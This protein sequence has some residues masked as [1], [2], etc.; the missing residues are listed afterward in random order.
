M[1][2]ACIPFITRNW[3]PIETGDIEDRKK[4]YEMIAV[5][6]GTVLEALYM[7]VKRSWSQRGENPHSTDPIGLQ[8]QRNPVLLRASSYTTNTHQVHYTVL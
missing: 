6:V 8:L 1:L 2:L 3:R 4:A 7:L 5:L